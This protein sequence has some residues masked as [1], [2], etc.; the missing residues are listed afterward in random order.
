MADNSIVDEAVKIAAGAG[1]LGGGLVFVR[2]F[3]GWL[4]FR[5]DRREDR[6]DKR[7]SEFMDAQDKRIKAYEDRQ[8]KQDVRLSTM[9]DE[10]DRC[11]QEKRDLEKRLAKLEGFATGRGEARG[12][13]QV[14]R[15]LDSMIKD[16]KMGQ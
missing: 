15:S 12:A 7:W 2:W 8:E 9:E 14:K 16:G 6:L 4:S 10:V 13:E 3:I 11:H 1:G 5:H